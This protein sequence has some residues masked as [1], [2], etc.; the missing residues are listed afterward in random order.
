VAE[1]AVRLLVWGR[2][3]YPNRIKEKRKQRGHRTERRSPGTGSSRKGNYKTSIVGKTKP[4][5]RPRQGLCGLGQLV[6]GGIDQADKGKKGRASRGPTSGAVLFYVKSQGLRVKGT[7][8]QRNPADQ[9]LPGSKTG[10]LSQ[11]GP[12][13]KKGTLLKKETRRLCAPEI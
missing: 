9:T 2:I 11:G 1:L 13:P 3:S 10:E 8:Y 6:W 4:T 12:T 7:Y 5:G